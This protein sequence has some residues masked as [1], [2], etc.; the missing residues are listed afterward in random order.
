MSYFVVGQSSNLTFM[1][2]FWKATYIRGIES[3]LY[4]KTQATSFMS[5]HGEQALYRH[6]RVAPFS[7]RLVY[8]AVV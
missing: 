7:R 8:R 6:K 1:L 4:R 2:R 5:I 3:V